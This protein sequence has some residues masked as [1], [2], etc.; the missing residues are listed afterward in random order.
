MSTPQIS[1]NPLDVIK[2]ANAYKAEDKPSLEETFRVFKSSRSSTR[3]ITDKGF[4]ITFTAYQYITQN[5]DAIEYLEKCI[6]EGVPGISDAGTTT[7][8]ELNPENAARKKYFAE[9]LAMQEE[10]ANPNRDM[11]AT[12]GANAVKVLSTQDT[13]K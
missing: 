10:L 11:G 5:K 12:A 4:R 8:E 1:K 6:A 3:L 13:P 7:A 9:F 2:A